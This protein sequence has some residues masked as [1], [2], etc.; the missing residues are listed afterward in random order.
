M[1]HS[2]RKKLSRNP[3]TI[4][5]GVGKRIV[6]PRCGKEGVLTVKEIPRKNSRYY[7][8]YI[9]HYIQEKQKVC[10][11]YYGPKKLEVNNI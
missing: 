3:Q 4:G 11:H 7:A 6:C 8:L 10:W 2:N 9:Y 5:S 1:T